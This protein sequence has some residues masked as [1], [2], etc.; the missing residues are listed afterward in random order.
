[1]FEK[2]EELAKNNK[3]IERESTKVIVY[4]TDLFKTTILMRQAIFSRNMFKKKAKATRKL[5]APP[6]CWPAGPRMLRTYFFRAPS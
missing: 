4:E 6:S 3:K 5:G 1:M 2:L